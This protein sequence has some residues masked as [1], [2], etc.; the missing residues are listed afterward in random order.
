MKQVTIHMA[1]GEEFVA[2]GADAERVWE[3]VHADS[4][5]PITFGKGQWTT[6]VF[7]QYIEAFTLQDGSNSVDF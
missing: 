5:A 3:L 2:E 6:T 7:R 1:S 4:M